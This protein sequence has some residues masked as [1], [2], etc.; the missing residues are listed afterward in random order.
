M[1]RPQFIAKQS[2]H[3]SGLLGVVVARI[4]DQETAE[5]NRTALDLL[6]LQAEDRFLDVGFG[7]GHALA[8]AGHVVTRGSLAGIDHSEVMYRLA[9]ARNARLLRCRRLQLTCADSAAIPFPDGQFNKVL[10]MHTV[11]FWK[12]IEAQ[13]KELRRVVSGDGG[14]V[15]IGYRPSDDRKFVHE[16]PADVY[17]MRSADEIEAAVGQAGF[18]NV[19]TIARRSPSYRLAWT[20]ADATADAEGQQ[21]PR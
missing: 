11:Y 3:P 5:A 1:R 13:F 16:F 15:V 18:H 7:A 4:M 21:E 2:R 6:D 14:R 8:A 17:R 19:R 12:D 20:V 9:R 10:S